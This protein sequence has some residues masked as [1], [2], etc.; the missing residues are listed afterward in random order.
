MNSLNAL[1]TTVGF[2][3][4]AAFFGSMLAPRAR[5]PRGVAVADRLETARCMMTGWGISNRDQSRPAAIPRMMGFVTIPLHV[6]PS[7]LRSRQ[8]PPGAISVRI[9]TAAML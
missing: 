6:L 1:L 5:S 3:Q 4:P 9:T 7:V 8:P 2:Q